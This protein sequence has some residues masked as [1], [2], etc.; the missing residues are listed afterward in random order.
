VREDFEK[1]CWEE[2]A[3]IT[4]LAR[5]ASHL[6]GEIRGFYEKMDTYGEWAPVPLIVVSAPPGGPTS[7][8]VWAEFM[9]KAE[10]SLRAALP[11]DAVYVCNHGASTA[12]HEDDTEGVMMKM[13]RSIVGSDIPVIATHDL[14]CN[15]SPQTVDALDALIAY[16]TNPHVDQRER[17]GE[18]ADL[19]NEMFS[20]IKTVKAFIRLPITPP[21]VTLLSARGP[22]ADLLKLAYSL[23]QK[24]SEGPIANVSVA[25]GF[26]FADVPKCGMTITVTSRGDLAA[27]RAAALTVARAAWAERAR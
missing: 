18:A 27:A 26:V 17:G 24:P 22:Y 9:Q 2:G 4:E 19:L 20:G 5:Q 11:V 3:R 12:D 6:P 10:A 16:R 13:I 14:H 8:E 21:S 25:G 23:M 7:D 1:S 15:V